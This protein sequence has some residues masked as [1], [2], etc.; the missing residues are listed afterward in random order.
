MKSKVLIA[1]DSTTIQK[2]V[3][4]TLSKLDLDL[5]AVASL[6]EAKAVVQQDRPNVLIVDSCLPGVVGADQIKELRREAGNVP[7]I[8]LVGSFEGASTDELAAKGLDNIVRKPFEP[9]VLTN[10]LFALLE[11]AET[12]ASVPTS[13]SQ[14]PANTSIKS[15]EPDFSGIPLPGP[16]AEPAGESD[17][18]L[19]VKSQLE[20]MLATKEGAKIFR[21]SIE[22]YCD[23]HFAALARE[24]IQ[25]EVR[26]LIDDR[27]RHSVDN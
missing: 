16:L 5:F 20:S 22:D 26:R 9:P 3:R 11:G 7:T 19:I 21:K 10:L 6:V 27:S 14:R 24:V 2:F 25:Q 18:D 13:L 23:R 12:V 15:L 8:V 4:M 17:A 1:D